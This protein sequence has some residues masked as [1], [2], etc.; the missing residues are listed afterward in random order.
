MK[1]NAKKILSLCILIFILVI[2]LPLDAIAA[3]S[4]D[5]IYIGNSVYSDISRNESGNGWKWD[6]AKFT[7]TLDGYQG[8]PILFISSSQNA[9]T[10]QIVVKNDNTLTYDAVPSNYPSDG[11]TAFAALL[12][13][14]CN[15]HVSGG[16]TLTMNASGKGSSCVF[17]TSKNM[18]IENITLK[19]VGEQQSLCAESIAVNNAT[20]Y[21]DSPE[22]YWCN[23]SNFEN[24]TI[25]FK[26]SKVGANQSETFASG[27]KHTFKKCTM[28]VLLGA[29]VLN[30]TPITATVFS[31]IA[32]YV[33]DNTSF[34]VKQGQHQHKDNIFTLFSLGYPSNMGNSITIKN[35]SRF[36]LNECVDNVFRAFEIKI[37]DSSITGVCANNL[38]SAILLNI[39]NSSL[40]VACTGNTSESAL[41]VGQDITISKST[42]QARAKGNVWAESESVYPEYV[43]KLSLV[44]SHLDLEGKTDTFVKA[45]SLN[46]SSPENWKV[47]L[48][49]TES[50]L[51]INSSQLNLRHSKV[52]V[53]YVEKAKVPQT[54]GSTPT[55]T[56]TAQPSVEEPTSDLPQ[57]TVEKEVVSEKTDTTSKKETGKNDAVTTGAVEKSNLPMII[58]GVIAMF[59]VGGVIVYICI[60]H[61]K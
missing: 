14:N 10:L 11:R 8:G 55:D 32:T 18:S 34:T 39:S 12:I 25:Y 15:V 44:D 17:S 43:E 29:R 23:S 19:C 22:G 31:G 35:N 5:K 40:D 33:F 47:V 38:F 56:T 3:N 58:I 6:A 26:N 60:K 61:K 9:N 16:G 52:V 7:L 42:V 30:T 13:E 24:T 20:M 1:R 45:Y 36:V 49:G 50:T 27:G 57:E 4:N 54:S 28:E 59:L 37:M 48:D 51:S 21:L 41:I 53:Q 46:Y 2:Q